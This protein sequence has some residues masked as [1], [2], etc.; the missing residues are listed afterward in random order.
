M[1]GLLNAAEVQA[2]IKGECN[3]ELRWEQILNILK[4][5]PF[6]LS[7]GVLRADFSRLRLVVG[8]A[9]VEGALGG[10]EA[11]V[12]KAQAKARP[13]SARGPA[14]VPLHA[15]K[16]ATEEL[17]SAIDTARDYLMAAREQVQGITGDQ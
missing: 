11:E 3:F 6:A 12:A 5:E 7:A 9:S 2:F 15:L 17:D 10:L 16:D 14:A 13:L 1:G 8:I 4:S